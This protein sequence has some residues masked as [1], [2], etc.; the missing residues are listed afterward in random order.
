MV[1]F[2]D[3]VK[4]EY[5]KFMRGW[6]EVNKGAFRW[7]RAGGGGIGINMT[8]SVGIIKRTVSTRWTVGGWHS[9]ILSIPR[10]FGKVR[11]R[12]NG[13]TAREGCE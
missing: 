3:F 10:S 13:S 7:L 5:G 12:W 8:T 9:G 4:S 1:A 6:N 2:W 11:E